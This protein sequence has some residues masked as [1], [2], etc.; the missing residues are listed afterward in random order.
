MN[1]SIFGIVLYTL[2]I[3]A[4]NTGTGEAQTSGVSTTKQM[5]NI[6]QDE[7]NKMCK[8]YAKVAKK[9]RQGNCT[10]DALTTVKSEKECKTV[11]SSCLDSIDAEP[12]DADECAKVDIAELTGCAATVSEVESCFSQLID[13]AKSLS[14]KDFGS[15]LPTAPDCMETLQ[16]QYGGGD[17]AS[18]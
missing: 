3:W 11:R 17:S 6:T 14:C 2:L 4:Y 16:N 12:A 15:A 8:E 10:L 7:A 1:K 13:Y 18:Q 9:I 5:G